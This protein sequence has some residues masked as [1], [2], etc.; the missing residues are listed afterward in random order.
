MDGI[1]FFCIA[2]SVLYY[3]ISGVKRVHVSLSTL[4]IFQV[5]HCVLMLFV[6]CGVGMSD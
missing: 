6:D 2:S 4:I 5:C 1:V 3:A